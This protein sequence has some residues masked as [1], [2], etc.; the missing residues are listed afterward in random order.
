MNELYFAY[1]SNMSVKQMIAR[2]GPICRDERYPR[3]ARLLGHRLAFNM[4]A[5]DGHVYANIMPG[6]DGVVGVIYRCDVEVLDKLDVYER[7][8][9][10]RRVEVLVDDEPT[11]AIAFVV[12][13]EFLAAE[14]APSAE[15]L[16]RIVTGARDHR[17]PDDYIRLIEAI[18]AGKL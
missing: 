9:E 5:E 18:A 15:Y 14:R 10:R 16:E 11:S 8:Y 6:G 3:T 12:L 2:T 4:G 1:G 7:G 17:L 13:P